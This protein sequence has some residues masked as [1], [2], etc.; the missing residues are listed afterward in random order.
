M[1]TDSLAVAM[2]T[3]WSSSNQREHLGKARFKPLITV[4]VCSWMNWAWDLTR[5]RGEGTEIIG[6]FKWTIRKLDG[7]FNRL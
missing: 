6:H 3:L 2:R 5:A 7:L 1:T 4:S